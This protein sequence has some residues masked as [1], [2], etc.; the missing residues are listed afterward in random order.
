MRTDIEKAQ[1]LID[2]AL[3][4]IDHHLHKQTDLLLTF[5]PTE[6]FLIFAQQLREYQSVLRAESLPPR[7]RYKNEMSS[8]IIN[9]WPY[10]FVG[11]GIVEAERAFLACLAKDEPDHS[12]E[13]KR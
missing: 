11:A 9:T 8:E 4:L 2:K 10:T 6:A 12:D 3:N 5:V 7:N 13:G 1:Y